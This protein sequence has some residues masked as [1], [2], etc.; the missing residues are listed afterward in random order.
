MFTLATHLLAAILYSGVFCYL[1]M[2]LLQQQTPNRNTLFVMV[3]SALTLHGAGLNS[4]IFGQQGVMLGIT[5]VSSVIFWVINCIV[6]LSCTR[7]PLHNVFILL[8]PLSM[9]AVLGAYWLPSSV[10]PFTSISY[11]IAWHILLSILAYSLLTIAT[12]QALLLAYQNRQLHQR[13]LT[14]GLR[15]F[16]PLQTMEALLFEI[17]WVGQILLSLSLASGFLFHDDLFAQHLAH[18]TVFSLIAWCVYSLLLWGR[19]RQGWRGNTAIRWTLGGF[20][21]L[22]LAY[23]GSKL[24]LEVILNI[25]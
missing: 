21:A 10:I 8:S 25:K 24:V 17:L 1:L 7:K 6:V 5:Q 2:A 16:P 3:A 23:F 9:L 4:D 20:A 15:F 22:M 14:R 12:L 11:G 13:Q 18:K 19:Y